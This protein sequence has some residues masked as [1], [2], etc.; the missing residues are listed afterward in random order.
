[1]SLTLE[2]GETYKTEVLRGSEN[3]RTW[4]FLIRMVLQAKDLWDVV[5]GKEVRPAGTEATEWD[6]KAGRALAIIALALSAE[7][8]E[9]IIDCDTPKQAWEVLEKLYEGKGRNRKF[10]LLQELF[11]AN[12]EA[13][14]R[15]MSVYLRTIREKISELAVTGLKLEDDVKLA[16][17][18]NGLPEKY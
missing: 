13:S 16:I 11:R 7:E 17:I 2:A 1:M 6:K 14:G 9:H 15:S 18:F 5:S 8:K 4:K 3:Y 10:M 12:M